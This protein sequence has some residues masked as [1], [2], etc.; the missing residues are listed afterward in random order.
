MSTEETKQIKVVG[1]YITIVTV[2]LIGALYKNCDHGCDP[3]ISS[4]RDEFI[5]LPANNME[6]A[7][8][9]VAEVVTEPQK[10][11]LCHCKHPGSIRT[12]PAPA[13]S[14]SAHQ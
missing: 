11:I 6:C 3:S 14:G 1:F 4:C 7:F 9:A 12:T 10:G 8:G 2:A 5:P 13:A